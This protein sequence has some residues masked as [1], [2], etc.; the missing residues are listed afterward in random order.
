MTKAPRG[1]P[2]TLKPWRPV[3]GQIACMPMNLAPAERNAARMTPGGCGI[4][5]EKQRARIAC[6]ADPGLIEPQ[7]AN[8]H[9]LRPHENGSVPVRSPVVLMA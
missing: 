9:S 2:E 8:Q 4:G 7:V 5:I 3:R 6:N 1:T